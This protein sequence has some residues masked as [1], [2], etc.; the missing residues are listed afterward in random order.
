MHA[1]QKPISAL[2]AMDSKQEKEA[3]AGD[4]SQHSAASETVVSQGKMELLLVVR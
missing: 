1:N 2:V 4:W 3:A